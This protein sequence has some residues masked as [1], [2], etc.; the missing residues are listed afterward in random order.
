MESFYRMSWLYSII[1]FEFISLREEMWCTRQKNKKSNP[2]FMRAW[3]TAFAFNAFRSVYV[4]PVPTKTIGCPVM[5]VIEMAA[6]T[7]KCNLRNEELVNDLYIYSKLSNL[8]NRIYLVVNGIEFGEHNAVN[9]MWICVGW[10]VSQCLIELN[11]LVDGFVSDQ[12]F[13]NE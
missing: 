3:T 6:P 9:D 4:W 8:V 11:K 12:G 7:W 5:Y 2:Y 1:S 10:M 13:T